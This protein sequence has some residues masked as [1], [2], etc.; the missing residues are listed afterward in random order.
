MRSKEKEARDGTARF[1][2]KRQNNEI[3][4][5]NEGE[6]AH[7]SSTALTHFCKIQTVKRPEGVGA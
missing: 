4:E 1:R 5:T 6:G 2:A 7:L 3:A